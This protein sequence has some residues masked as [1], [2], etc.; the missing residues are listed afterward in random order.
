ME[1][2]IGENIKRIRLSNNLTQ[3][4]FGKLLGFSARTVSDWENCNTE[5]DLTTLKKIAQVFNMRYE[6]ILD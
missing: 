1:K 3:K 5:P 4:E 6:D 2:I